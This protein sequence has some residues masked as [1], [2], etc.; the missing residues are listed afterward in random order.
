[1]IYHLKN[2]SS[3]YQ[4][5]LQYFYVVDNDFEISL[6]RKVDLKEYASKLLQNG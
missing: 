4:L 5:L 1:M 2:K 6:S 3:D